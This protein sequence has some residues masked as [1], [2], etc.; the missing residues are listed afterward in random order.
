MF[1]KKYHVLVYWPLGPLDNPWDGIH[2]TESRHRSKLGVL[3]YLSSMRRLYSG[4]TSPV[5]TKAIVY[6]YTG[7]PHRVTL[8]YL[9]SHSLW[10]SLRSTIQQKATTEHG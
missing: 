7:K 6:W 4:L 1:K 5:F 9:T 10:S 3:I 2:H 8:G